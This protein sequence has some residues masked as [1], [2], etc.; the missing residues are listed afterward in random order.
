VNA[1]PLGV[2]I[3]ATAWG[4]PPRGF[5]SCVIIRRYQFVIEASPETGEVR[6][7][8]QEIHAAAN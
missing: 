6:A 4:R 5:R 3:M 2:H 7:A 1:A 8:R